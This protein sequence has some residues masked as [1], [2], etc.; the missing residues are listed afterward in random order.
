MHCVRERWTDTLYSYDSRRLLTPQ[1]GAL[2]LCAAPPDRPHNVQ[3]FVLDCAVALNAGIPHRLLTLSAEGW[4]QVSEGFETRSEP[5]KL[6]K[7]LVPAAIW[8]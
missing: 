2:L 6:R 5:H 7:T 8:E 3:L 4:V 1:E